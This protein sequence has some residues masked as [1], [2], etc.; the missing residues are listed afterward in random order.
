MGLKSVGNVACSPTAF[1]KQSN[2]QKRTH[3]GGKRSLW[4]FTTQCCRPCVIVHLTK[5]FQ[6]KRNFLDLSVRRALSW[7]PGGPEYLD[8]PRR[9]SWM[10]MTP[11]YGGKLQ[12][13]TGFWG[14]VEVKS[15]EAC[16]G[17]WPLYT[18]QLISMLS[19]KS[20]QDRKVDQIH[21]T[22]EILRCILH[23]LSPFQTAMFQLNILW[24][25]RWGG[26]VMQ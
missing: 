6:S 19:A 21:P 24:T 8:R 4:D 12:H 7:N 22:I 20:P 9:S 13:D 3:E 16:F 5:Q 11:R 1:R 2:Y 18:G 26:N 14:N 10:A 17:K 15:S 25:Q 23:Q